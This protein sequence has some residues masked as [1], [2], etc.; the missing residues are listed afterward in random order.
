MIETHETAAAPSNE[1]VFTDYVDP[2]S[3]KVDQDQ[4]VAV[5]CCKIYW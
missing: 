5:S 4:P 1:S 3:D 2:Q